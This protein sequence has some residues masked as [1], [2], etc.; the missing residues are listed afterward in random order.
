MPENVDVNTL[1]DLVARTSRIKS[2]LWRYNVLGA[3]EKSR[4][5]ENLSRELL[6]DVKE[7]ETIGPD[8]KL[9]IV[10]HKY[11]SQIFK[12]FLMESALIY[13]LLSGIFSTLRNIETF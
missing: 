5:D 11:F 10:R 2:S 9:L 7:G 3:R 4:L 13:G 8:Q 6:K 12:R 1:N